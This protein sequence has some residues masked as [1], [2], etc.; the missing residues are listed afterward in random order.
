MPR[1]DLTPSKPLVARRGLKALRD[2]WVYRANKDHL[3]LQAILARLARR[4]TQDRRDRQETTALPA[5]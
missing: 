3:D 5:K 4:E 1:N 2:L